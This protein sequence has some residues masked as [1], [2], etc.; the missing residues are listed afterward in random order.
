[1]SLEQ[2]R[3]ILEA[4]I[5]QG[6][7]KGVYSLQDIAQILQALQS[8]YSLEEQK[9]EGKLTLTLKM[10]KKTAIE[11]RLKELFLSVVQ[12]QMSHQPCPLVCLHQVQLL[13]LNNLLFKQLQ[14]QQLL[15]FQL[16]QPKFHYYPLLQKTLYQK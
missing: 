3:Q 1:M 8:L 6:V 16:F 15:L 13:L 5:N 2:A 4:A 7:L 11:M 9:Q 14:H 12:I 10:K